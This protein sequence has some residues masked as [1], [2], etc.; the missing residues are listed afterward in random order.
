MSH[1]NELGRRR[2]PSS[3][4]S[5]HCRLCGLP[6]QS[7]ALQEGTVAILTGP[8]PTE[9]VCSSNYFSC[10]CPRGAEATRH[11]SFCICGFATRPYSPAWLYTG[12]L[13]CLSTGGRISC[14]FD[15]SKR[16]WRDGWLDGDITGWLLG[17]STG[18]ADGLFRRGC[19]VGCTVGIQYITTQ[20][21]THHLLS[22]QCVVILYANMHTWCIQWLLCRFIAYSHQWAQQRLL[23]VGISKSLVVNNSIN[24]FRIITNNQHRCIWNSCLLLLASELPPFIKFARWKRKG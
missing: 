17:S 18:W 6:S 22:T 15:G 9:H 2:Y 11:C 14:C 7:P 24:S 12:L 21:V 16:G 1:P 20:Y 10:L 4:C 5:L 13:S 19:S 23:L 8:A 3:C